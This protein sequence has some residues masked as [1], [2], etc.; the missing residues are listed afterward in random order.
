MKLPSQVIPSYEH[1][2]TEGDDCVRDAPKDPSDISTV[3]SIS[4]IGLVESSNSTV[5]SADD[6]TTENSRGTIDDDSSVWRL[7][8]YTYSSKGN[9]LSNILSSVRTVTYIGAGDISALG[10]YDFFPKSS[11]KEKI[12]A[13]FD[14][15]TSKDGDAT[16]YGCPIR[17]K[18]VTCVMRDESPR[19]IF[20]GAILKN[21]KKTADSV[22]VIA[23]VCLNTSFENSSHNII[24]TVGST[25]RMR[26]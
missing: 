22:L 1:L 15:V 17:L 21:V 20:L 4:S 16:S 10:G 14:T 13:I 9:T 23:Y 24:Y 18:N 2:V 11:K 7:S 12:K 26:K 3:S 25:E 5:I 8:G 19:F 6:N